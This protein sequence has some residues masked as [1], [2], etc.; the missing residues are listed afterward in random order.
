MFGRSQEEKTVWIIPGLE[1]REGEVRKLNKQGGGGRAPQRDRGR[2]RPSRAALA[3]SAL[4]SGWGWGPSVPAEPGLP[5]GM[6][7][8][9]D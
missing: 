6:R 7:S 5:V 8:S 2:N 4:G 1:V 3:S 9:L